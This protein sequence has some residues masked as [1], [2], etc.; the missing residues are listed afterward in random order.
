[1]RE[2]AAHNRFSRVYFFLSLCYATIIITGFKKEKAD[3]S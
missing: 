1:M 2:T 3:F